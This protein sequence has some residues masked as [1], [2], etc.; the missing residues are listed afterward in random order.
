MRNIGNDFIDVHVY[1][2]YIQ[3]V[4]SYFFHYVYTQNC[5]LLYSKLTHIL[6]IQLI[7][8]VFL[9]PVSKLKTH[10]K[11]ENYKIVP[12]KKK[13]KKIEKRRTLII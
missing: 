10:T 3:I 4:K 13:K 12:E 7:L 2:H 11:E 5:F 9:N 8:F 1:F 6:I